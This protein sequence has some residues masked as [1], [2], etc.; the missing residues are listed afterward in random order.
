MEPE[1]STD[2]TLIT[3]DFVQCQSPQLLTVPLLNVGV[4]DKDKI[5]N[6]SVRHMITHKSYTPIFIAAS[7]LLV[8][9]SKISLNAL[10]PAVP[11]SRF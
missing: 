1:A 6:G 9:S 4:S 3:D 5:S 7:N 10:Y 2:I 11:T 8:K